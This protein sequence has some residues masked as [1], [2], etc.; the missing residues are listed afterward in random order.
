MEWTNVGNTKPLFRAHY[1]PRVPADL[2][3]EYGVEGF[4]Y[5]HCWFGNGKKLLKRPLSEVLLSG[6]PDFPFCLG[7]TNHSWKGI[8]SGVKSKDSLIEQQ[9]NGIKDYSLYF[10]E[11][12]PAFKFT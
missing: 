8:Y 9:Y 6:K 7:W 11:I 1:Q 5:W 12:L 3:Q 10:Y 4:C 2:A